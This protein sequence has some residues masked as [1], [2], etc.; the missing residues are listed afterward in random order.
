[1]FLELDETTK[2]RISDDIKTKTT[3]LERRK[4]IFIKELGMF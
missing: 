4:N 2:I 3:L 1:M